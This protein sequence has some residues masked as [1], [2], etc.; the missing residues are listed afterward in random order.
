M[1]A[2][3]VTDITLDIF[4]EIKEKIEPSYKRMISLILNGDSLQ[5]AEESKAKEVCY[6][7]IEA[8]S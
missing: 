7:L 4:N 5:E 2:N 3:I 1:N 6:Y 8:M